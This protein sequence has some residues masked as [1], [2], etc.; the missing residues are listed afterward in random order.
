[1]SNDTDDEVDWDPVYRGNFE[2]RIRDRSAWFSAANALV[3]MAELI[4]PRVLEFWEIAKRERRFLEQDFHNVLLMLY[5]FAIEN[6]C[7]GRLVGTLPAAEQQQISAGILPD[8]LRT[9]N[10][11]ELVRKIG[12]PTDVATEN[13]L[14]RMSAACTW[15]GRYPTPAFYQDTKPQVHADG[16]E[17]STQ[18]IGRS[19][20]ERVPALEADVRRLVGAPRSYVAKAKVPTDNPQEG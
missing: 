12:L 14:R 15:A 9:H 20:L 1:V 10:L 7:K 3:T 4:A 5:G 19:D 16:K 8:T 17:Y 13:L 11:L 18:W 6:L 2:A